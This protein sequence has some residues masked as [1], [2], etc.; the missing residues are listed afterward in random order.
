MS[1]DKPK[2]LASWKEKQSLRYSLLSAPDEVRPSPQR[3][4]FAAFLGGCLLGAVA[5][6]PVRH[7]LTPSLSCAAKPAAAAAGAQGPGR[8][9]GARRAEARPATLCCPS[10]VSPSAR[11]MHDRVQV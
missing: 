4:C 9:E 6:Q 8:E 10:W 1:A 11:R 5:L 2:S 7:V 3:A